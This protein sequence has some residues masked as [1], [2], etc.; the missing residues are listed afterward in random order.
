MR[1]ASFFPKEAKNKG[2]MLWPQ[3]NGTCQGE[4]K[5]Y[6]IGGILV[7]RDQHYFHFVANVEQEEMI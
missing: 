2:V 6:S 7:Y 3:H 1:G 5:N 4:D